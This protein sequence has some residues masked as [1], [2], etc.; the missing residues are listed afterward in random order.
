MIK[1]PSVAVIAGVLLPH[2]ARRDTRL[3]PQDSDDE[4][5]TERLRM[6]LGYWREEASKSGRRLKLPRMPLLLRDIWMG[7][8]LLFSVLMFSTTWIFTVPMVSHLFL[9]LASLPIAG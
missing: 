3:L 4:R 5:H 7:A 6:M 9:A 2:L 1:R 8:M